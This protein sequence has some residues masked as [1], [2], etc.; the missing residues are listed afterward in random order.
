MQRKICCFVISLF[1]TSFALANV[2][3]FKNANNIISLQWQ[4]Q[5]YQSSMAHPVLTIKTFNVDVKKQSL[6]NFSDLFIDQKQALKII[7]TYSQRYFTKKILT[8]SMTKEDVGRFVGMIKTGT[9]PRFE[10]YHYWNIEGEYLKIT[11]DEAQVLPRYYGPQAVD[12][13]LS[14]FAN[15]LNPNLFPTIFHLQV[16]DLLFQDLN[17]GQLCDGIN[18]TTYGYKHRVV[19]HVGMVV[20]RQDSGAQVIEAVSAGVT[21]TPLDEF[22]LRSKDD[23]GHPRVM[24]GRV[25]DRI[26]R[27]IPAA[28]ETARKNVG[29]PYNANFSLQGKGFYCTQLILQSFLQANQGKVV[30]TAHPMNFKEEKSNTFSAAW[31]HYFAELKQAIPQGQLG[32][33]PGRLSRDP[34]IDIIYFYGK[35]RPVK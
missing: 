1:F 2:T 19:S 14:L 11:F 31:A 9:A 28:V 16:G 17:C 20:S 15:F 7:S 22:L 18:S 4:D 29:A 32:S 26:K 5:F 24:V 25:N 27:L 13:P 35:L 12:I 33:N 10:N 8:E 3:V 30:F 23:L 6:L 21:L 34:Q